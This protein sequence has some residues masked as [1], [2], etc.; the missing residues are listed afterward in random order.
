MADSL[1]TRI[2][3]SLQATLT[4]AA[5]LVTASAPISQ[6]VAYSWS[7][8]LVID[9]ADKVYAARLALSTTPTD[10]DLAGSLTDPLGAAVTFAKVNGIYL[11]NRSTTAAEI[12]TLGGDAAAILLGGA[13][14]HTLKV[15]PNGMLW[16]ANPSLAGYAVT[17]TT[18][19]ILQLVADAG[20]PSV[21]IV[22]IGRS[23]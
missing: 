7:D 21:D 13:A 4:N 2:S 16:I 6:S 10:L 17:G 18:G 8:G 15:G 22:I 23:A 19:D 1:S 5:D 12:V 9:T 20:T 14:T 11:K 3:F